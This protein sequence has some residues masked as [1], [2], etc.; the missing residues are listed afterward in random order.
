MNNN[1]FKQ[2]DINILAKRAANI[3]ANPSCRALTSGPADSSTQSVSVGEAAHIYGAE[4]G[5]A[6]YDNAMGAPMR[7]DITNGIWLCCNCHKLIDTDVAG[8]PPEIL[9]EWKREHEENLASN[10]GKAGAN[11]WYKFLE[12]KLRDFKNESYLAQQI[13]I[14]KPD[15]WEYKLTAEL[16]RSKLFPIILR[17][18]HLN[19]GLYAKRSKRVIKQDSITCF[20]DLL[21]DLVKQFKALEI[22]VNREFA[23]AFGEPGVPGSEI[24]ILRTCNLFEEAFQTLLSWEEDIQFLRVDEIFKRL[25]GLLQGIGAHVMRTFMIIPEKLISLLEEDAKGQ[26]AISVTLTLPAGWEEEVEKEIKRLKR[27]MDRDGY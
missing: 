6:R 4:P 20:Q 18:Q 13:V 22:I 27:E 19:E 2:S 11:A 14:D 26:H 9:F 25:I 7:A 21:N 12:K 17:L 3:C 1:R 16:L 10:I 8:Y 23:I 24:S 5:S 15:C